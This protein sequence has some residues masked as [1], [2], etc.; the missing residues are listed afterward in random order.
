VAVIVVVSVMLG[1]VFVV[2]GVAKVAAPQQWRSQSAGLGVPRTIA[3]VVPAIELVVGASLVAQLARR[4]SAVVAIVML[5]AF[6]T[7]LVVRLKQ[8]RRP[9]CA[10][11][12]SLTSKPIG[13]SDVVRNVVFIALAVAAAAR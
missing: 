7:L 1:A 5:L 3:I 13:W 10:C 2:S 9:P 8:G 6:T 11:F 12:G 4:V